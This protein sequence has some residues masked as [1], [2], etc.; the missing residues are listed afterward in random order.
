MHV[1]LHLSFP[2]HLVREPMVYRLG[3]E[4]DLV[5]NIR[6]ANV[7]ERTAWFII[8]VEG[9]EGDVDRAVSW[10]ESEGVRVERIPV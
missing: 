5:T 3:R 1:Q 10:L 6:R 4:F 9:A 2:E 7:D 8:D